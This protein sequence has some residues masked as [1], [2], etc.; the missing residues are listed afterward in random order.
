MKIFAAIALCI[1]PGVAHAEII[2]G[3]A[4]VA[5]GDSLEMSGTRIRLFG[6]DAPEGRQTCKRDGVDWRCGEEA[7]A[8][9]RSLVDGRQVV[10]T[11]RD[12][13]A[14]GRTVAICKADGLE[15]NHT[16]VEAGFAVALPQ[17]TDRYADAEAKAQQHRLGMWASE[18]QRPADYRAANKVQEATIPRPQPAPLSA[19]RRSARAP[20]PY[21]G[22]CAIKGNRNRKGQWIY[23]LP[24]MPYYDATRP[25]EIFCTEAQAQAAGYRRAIVK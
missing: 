1:L 19:P 24:G 13:D 10:C 23:H 18:F 15:L 21:S 8:L 22:G 17:F 11:G 4:R 14:Y 9:L 25:E 16:M 7:A 2:L 5:E 3:P 6:I 20:A 12:T